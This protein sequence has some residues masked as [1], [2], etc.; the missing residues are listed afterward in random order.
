MISIVLTGRNDNYGDCFE[1][2][3]FFTLRENQKLLDRIG[4]GYEIVFVEWNPISDRSFLS[5]KLC[6]EFPKIRA[7]IV[8]HD[9]HHS[10]CTNKNMNFCEMPAK[11]VG[12]RRSQGSYVLIIN[13]DIILSKKIVQKI[14]KI[15]PK[16]NEIYR[17]QRVDV[18]SDDLKTTWEETKISIIRNGEEN[19]PPVDYLGAGGDFCFAR[20]SVFEE[21]GGFEERFCFTTRGKDWR[22]YMSAKVRGVNIR[23]LGRVFHLEHDEGFRNTDSEQLNSDKAHFGRFWNLQHQIPYVNTHFWGMPNLQHQKSECKNVFILKADK[24]F[25]NHLSKKQDYNDRKSVVAKNNSSGIKGAQLL[26]LFLDKKLSDFSFNFIF[27]Q[28]DTKTQLVQFDQ[29]EIK[30]RTLKHG[31]PILD[32]GERVDSLTINNEEYKLP[33][34]IPTIKTDPEFNPLLIQRL[35][36]AYKTLEKLNYSKLVIY[37]L[38]GHTLQILK[39]G[40][41]RQ[42]ELVGFVET[43]KSLGEFHRYD[44][45]QVEDLKP[46]FVDVVLLSSIS[47][48]NEMLKNCESKGWNRV[49]RLYGSYF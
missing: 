43:N 9:I 42:F 8:P 44:V 19:I 39:I 7:F 12:I 21:V 49:Y 37:G 31:Y 3:I 18:E 17:A 34:N 40:I 5:E 10:Y 6:S 28:E 15:V 22:F 24:E 1:E 33:V 41:P 4:I 46:E 20:K 23:F 30:L 32:I 11:N 13:A 36:K 48:E 29:N 2:R 45:F 38:G 26:H 35:F 27:E 14:S 47:Y 16:Y 25:K